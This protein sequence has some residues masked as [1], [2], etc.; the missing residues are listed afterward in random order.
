MIFKPRID[1]NQREARKD[2]T[3]EISEITE[4][5]LSLARHKED[6]RI[7]RRDADNAD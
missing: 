1:A 3:T 2:L 6:K 5:K 7:V 4:N